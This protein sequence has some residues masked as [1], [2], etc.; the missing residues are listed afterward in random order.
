MPKKTRREKQLA[1]LH[2][3]YR[4][5]HFNDPVVR[6]NHETRLPFDKIP[7]PIKEETNVVGYFLAD[8]KKSLSIISIIIT[9][10]I[11]LYFASMFTY[12]KLF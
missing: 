4:L 5:L 11:S 7:I 12:L 9:L 1:H 6:P 2:K 3:K 10:E 8:L